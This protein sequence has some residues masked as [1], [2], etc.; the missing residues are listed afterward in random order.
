M[1]SILRSWILTHAHRDDEDL[2]FLLQRFQEVQQKGI[3]VTN[4]MLDDLAET[5][6][7]SRQEIW[8]QK[9]RFESKGLLPVRV[10]N[11]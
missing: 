1:V 8:A 10:M 2:K 5:L 7:R 6:E 11:P 3:N 9:L 4:C